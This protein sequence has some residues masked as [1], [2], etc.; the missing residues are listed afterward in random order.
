MK[1]IAATLVL[2]AAA[3]LVVGIVAARGG[4]TATAAAVVSPKQLTAAG[5]SCIDPGYWVHCTPPGID[6][7]KAPPVIVSLNFYT[8]DPNAARARFLGFED[9][10]R[11]DIWRKLARH[12]PCG[13]NGKYRRVPGNSLPKP[14]YMYCHRFNDKLPL[15]KR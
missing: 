12:W 9:L 15:P 2:S 14:G 4:S 13:T 3:V 1:R 11:L 6:V 10:I 8:R 5:W 7:A